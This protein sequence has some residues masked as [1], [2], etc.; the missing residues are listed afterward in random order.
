[1]GAQPDVF[2]SG[3]LFAVLFVGLAAATKA[4]RA[5]ALALPENNASFPDAEHGG[6]QSDAA[7]L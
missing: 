3:V 2:R 1:M 4:K 7:S 5:A 6:A